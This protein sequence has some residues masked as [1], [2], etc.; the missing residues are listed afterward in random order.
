MDTDSGVIKN[1]CTDMLQKISKNK[2]HR[3]KKKYFNPL[4]AN[5]VSINSPDLDLVSDEE[6]Q[7][8]VKLWSTPRHK[9]CALGH[10]NLLLF[11]HFAIIYSLVYICGLFYKCSWF[12]FC[13]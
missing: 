8:L 7:M 10:M 1:T 11:S 3:I 6:W 5:Q 4:P 12:I 13:T 9:V 2:R